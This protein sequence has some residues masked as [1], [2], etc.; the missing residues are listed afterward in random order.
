MPQ[1]PSILRQCTLVRPGR[2]I[3]FKGPAGRLT[4]LGQPVCVS[5]LFPAGA[6]GAPGLFFSAIPDRCGSCEGRSPVGPAAVG[7]AGSQ[8]EEYPTRV[9]T[10]SDPHGQ[11][12]LL[13][14]YFLWQ[15]L[16]PHIAA[17]L[18]LLCMIV[19]FGTNDGFRSAGVS[20][21]VFGLVLYQK[22]A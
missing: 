4:A 14:A 1:T 5:R 22:T 7:C 12:R 13:R 16:A 17:L 19:L 8:V 2:V 9:K 20:P 10:I 21:A 18:I 15:Y 3:E 11:E 6:V